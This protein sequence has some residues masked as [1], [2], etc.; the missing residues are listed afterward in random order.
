VK[1]FRD[2]LKSDDVPGG[3][4]LSIGNFDGVH[5]GH[6]AVLRHVVA[7]AREIGVVSAAMTFDP[8][9][10]KLLRPREAPK[11]L[12]TLEQRLQIIERTGIE[13]ALVVPF[14]HQLARMEAM[15]FIGRVLIDRLEVREVYIG[16]NFR[17]GADRKGDVDLLVSQ[18][19]QRGF[20]A[21]SAPIVCLDDEI[22]SSSRVRSTVMRGDVETAW[23]LLD[24]PVHVDGPVLQGK[25]LGR[26]L[27]FPTLNIQVE[28]DLLPSHGVYVTAVHIPSFERVF[29]SVTNIGIRPT[30]YENSMVTVESHLVDFVADVYQERVRLYFLK[31]LRDEITFNSPTQLMAQI[32]R[33]VEATKLWFLNN[34]IDQLD[35]MR[36]PG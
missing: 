18:G 6:Q 14:T 26:E 20:N 32:S 1:V 25:R 36:L 2:P 34:Q 10:V 9:P 19:V 35:L 27:G 15:D 13:I 24:R 7:R 28:N 5:I 11:L 30:L 23:R 17:F 22:V 8:H 3:S 4:I 29:P 33:D 31:R 21:A 12:S 16:R